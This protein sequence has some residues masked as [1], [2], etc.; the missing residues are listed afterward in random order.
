[1]CLIALVVRASHL[2]DIKSML[3]PHPYQSPIRNQDRKQQTPTP[4]SG[5]EVPPLT[6]E[7]YPCHDI[8][9]KG[10]LIYLRIRNI[11]CCVC[12]HHGLNQSPRSKGSR[13]EGR[14]W[15]FRRIRFSRFGSRS[16]IDLLGEVRGEVTLDG[17]AN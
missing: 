11:V 1:V 6:H 7:M 3:H 17:V 5:V 8:S 14:G 13:R 12:A 15:G 2:L 4:T 9:Q 10:H 16:E